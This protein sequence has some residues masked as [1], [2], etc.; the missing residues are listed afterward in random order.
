MPRDEFPT[1]AVASKY[2]SAPAMRSLVLTFAVL[3]GTGLVALEDHVPDFGL[4]FVQDWACAPPMGNAIK[5]NTNEYKILPCIA[6]ASASVSDSALTVGGAA[7]YY[8]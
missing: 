5:P 2:V 6:F 8:S 1:V 4:C 3:S 7:D